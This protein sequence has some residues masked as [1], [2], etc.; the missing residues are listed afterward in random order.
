MSVFRWEGMTSER[1]IRFYFNKEQRDIKLPLS[2]QRAGRNRIPILLQNREKWS[3]LLQKWQARQGIES[4]HQAGLT[5]LMDLLQECGDCFS[6]GNRREEFGNFRLKIPNLGNFVMFICSFKLKKCVFF[7]GNSTWWMSHG[8]TCPFGNSRCGICPF[9]LN[10]PQ[11]VN[12]F[13][14]LERLI[15]FSL[16]FVT[17]GPELWLQ[18]PAC[19]LP[20]SYSQFIPLFEHQAQKPR[21][22]K[23]ERENCAKSS[24]HRTVAHASPTKNERAN[25]LNHPKHPKSSGP[26][27]HSKPIPL[28][29]PM[30]KPRSWDP[31]HT[32]GN[33]HSSFF[34]ASAFSLCSRSRFSFSSIFLL[35]YILTPAKAKQRINV[36]AAKMYI[37]S[38]KLSRAWNAKESVQ[39][40]LEHLDN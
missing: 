33:L 13:T 38:G 12:N 7:S 27:A 28:G 3:K 32:W 8:R 40:P 1:E 37:S 24:S 25:P 36:L 17:S 16:Y 14:P 21:E 11:A 10:H 34:S 39:A 35:W 4:K 9:Q 31:F 26:I 30:S 5:L 19:L 20:C 18:H 6:F 22:T 15:I 2:F 29:F 23:A